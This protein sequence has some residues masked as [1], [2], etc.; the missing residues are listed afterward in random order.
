[1]ILGIAWSN[2]ALYISI[3]VNRHDTTAGRAI[4]W[5]TLAMASFFAGVIRSLYARLFLFTVL[6]MI[7]PIINS[8]LYVDASSVS[9]F[10]S[11]RMVLTIR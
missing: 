2:F 1:M 9:P 10:L 6:F 8:V 11:A 3:L 4:L 5:V 7:P